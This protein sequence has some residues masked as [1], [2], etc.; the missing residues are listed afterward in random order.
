MSRALRLPDADL[1]TSPRTGWTRD[2][3]TAVADHWLGWVRDH[4][5]TPALPRLPGRV[6]R[7]GERRESME[8]VCRSM[9]LAAAR[10]ARARPDDADADEIAAWY[11]EALV[12]GTTPGGPQE[13]PRAVTGRL[14]RVG[15]TQPLVE[16]ANAA[17]ALH[18]ARERLW[19][20]LAPGERDQVARWLRHHARLDTWPNNWQL[21]PA[22]AEGFLR[23]VGLEDTDVGELHVARM[24]GWYVGDGWYTDGPE[25]RFD[26]YNAWAIHPYLWAW[27]RMT[28]TT[29][30]AEGER[31]LDRLA[32]YVRSFARLVAPDGALLHQGRSLTYRTAALAAGWCAEVSGV[33][34]LDP[35]QWRRLAS[36]VL[37]DFVEHGVGVGG[38]LSLG[39]YGPHEGSTQYYS[40]FGSPYYAGIGFLG[41]ALAD[42]AAVWTAVEPA[43]DPSDEVTP[44]PRVGWTVARAGGVCRLV[45]HGA[46]HVTMA[47]DDYPDEDDPHYAKLSY[48]THTAPETGRGFVANVDSHLAVLDAG[49]QASRRTAVRG[50]RVEGPVSGSVHLPHLDGRP[51]PGAAVR[52]VSVTHGP[53]EVRCHLVRTAEPRMVREGAHAVADETP[54]Q[55]GSWGS[56]GRWARGARGVLAAVAPLHGYERADVVRGEGVNAFGPHSATPYLIGGHVAGERVYVALHLLWLDP[57]A[58]AADLA[59]SDPRAVVDVTVA[60]S[61]VGVRWADDGATTRTDLATFVPWDGVTAGG[62]G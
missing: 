15:L 34:P 7:D 32:A 28:D 8:T 49:G 50:V 31:H 57:D 47:L 44:I 29:G 16:A 40:G 30:T 37:R 33:S 13:W 38:P 22:V 19:D 1:R 4:S 11:R 10:V 17:F 55:A 27:Y 20:A 41:L 45:N 54:P 36:G 6:T 14:P 43:H 51:L 58:T 59:A 62:Q 21:F 60:G 42:D 53:W 25:H 5:P 23:S 24:E 35:G 26:H 39:W 9:I 61:V 18:L 3:W 48:S 46:D 56:G 52:T 12:A 2:H